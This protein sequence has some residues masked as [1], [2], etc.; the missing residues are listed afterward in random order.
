M[1]RGQETAYREAFETLA[2]PLFRHAFFRLSDRERA[3]DLVQEAFLKTWDHLV[4]GGEVRHFRSF[5]YRT[6]NNLIIDEY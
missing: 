5:L 4:A 2:D 3:Y 6:L 1:E